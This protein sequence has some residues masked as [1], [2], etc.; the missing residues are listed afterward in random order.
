MN[1]HA[2]PSDESNESIVH[3]CELP[4]SREKVWRALTVPEILAEWLMPDGQS[5][6]CE[7]V[8]AERPDRIEYRWREGDRVAVESTVT[9]EL[10]DTPDG[11]THLRITHDDFELAE[12]TVAVFQPIFAQPRSPRRRSRR[13]VNRRASRTRAMGLRAALPRAA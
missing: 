3:E 12:E 1:P 6:E 13:T 7:V 5:V 10:S 9:I 2:S 4:E 11:G 8:S